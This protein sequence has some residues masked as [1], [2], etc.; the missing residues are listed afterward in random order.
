VKVDYPTG[1]DTTFTYDDA[2]RKTTMVDGT[3]TTTWS[4]NNASEVTSLVQPQGAMAYSYNTAGQRTVATEVGL[5]ALTNVYDGTNG[6]LMTQTNRFSETTTYAYDSAGRVQRKTLHNGQYEEYTYDQRN[7]VMTMNLYPSGGGTPLRV[8]DYTLDAASQVTKLISGPQTTFYTYDDH[9]QLTREQ[10]TAGVVFDHNY[11][12]DNNGNRLTRNDGTNSDVYSYDDGDKLLNVKRNL[13]NWRE[14]VYDGAGN[15]TARKKWISRGWDTE[16]LTYDWQDRMVT[17]DAGKNKNAEHVYNGVNTRVATGKIGQAPNNTFARD[18]VGVT[19]PVMRDSGAAYTPGTSERRSGVST[20]SHSGIKNANVQTSST[21][22]IAATRTYDAFGNTVA[23]TGTWKG[24]FGYAGQFGYQ[25]DASGL[26][27]LG[28]RYYDAEIG[29]FI[30]KDP[31]K[32]GRN[33]YA[34]CDNNPITSYDED[35]LWVRELGNADVWKD[36][37]KTSAAALGSAL[38]LGIW[39]GGEAKNNPGFAESVLFW[40]IAGVAVSAGSGL[41]AKAGATVTVTVGK[42]IAKQL[43][44]RGWTEKLI[45]KLVQK[46]ARKGKTKDVR[47]RPDGTKES[48]NATVYYDKDGNYVVINDR[49]GEVVQVSNRKDPNWLPPK[50]IK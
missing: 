8:E 17:Q 23:S 6:R 28:N 10:G 20:F 16:T 3:G 36:G 41:A 26:K 42:K 30:T 33:W 12:Y 19:A 4:Y 15:T 2:N 43:K 48:D 18:G 7:R 1:P 21:G 25:E 47:N 50:E 37:L 11:T 13:N 39:D 44:P 31:I 34:Y 49:T 29:R 45:R 35:G 38:T 46:P 9:S 27:L 22:A 40:E 5:G 24:P 32:D 14:Y